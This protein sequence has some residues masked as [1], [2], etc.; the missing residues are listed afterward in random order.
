MLHALVD[1]DWEFVAVGAPAFLVLGLLVGLGAERRVDR[2]V[3]PVVLSVAAVGVLYSLIAPNVS[4]RL[5]DS[6]YN[7]IASGNTAQALSTA[8]RPAG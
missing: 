6:A 8:A 3:V 4:G 5:V 2:P 1:I 7:A